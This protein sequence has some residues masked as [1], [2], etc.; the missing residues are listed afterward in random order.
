MLALSV[1]VFGMH[2]V[3]VGGRRDA[4]VVISR[5]SSLSPS[6]SSKDG[7]ASHF[8][9]PTSVES[10]TNGHCRDWEGM[11]RWL[12][13]SDKVAVQWTGINRIKGVRL[14]ARCSSR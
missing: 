8:R 6:S 12:R 11:R 13:L 4:V 7:Q 14:L 5:L 1:V 3:R 2:S 10:R 9:A